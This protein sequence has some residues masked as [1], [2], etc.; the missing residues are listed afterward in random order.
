MNYFNF[1][2]K[3]LKA[4]VELLRLIFKRSTQVDKKC[5]GLYKVNIE[6]CALCQNFTFA[7]LY[8]LI[9]LKSTKKISFL[10]LTL[11]LTL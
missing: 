11:T 10:R 8:W 9:T 2:I 3:T 7:K 4:L 5:I 6:D 1:W